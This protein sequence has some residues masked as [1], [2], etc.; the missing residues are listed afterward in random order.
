[1]K[2]EVAFLACSGGKSRIALARVAICGLGALFFLSGV[3]VRVAA[4]EAGAP[5]EESVYA[6]DGVYMGVRGVY[7]I[8]DFDTDFAVDDGWGFG[9]GLRRALWRRSGVLSLPAFR[10]DLRC[11]LQP[12]DGPHRRTRLMV[13]WLR[14]SPVALLGE[15][16]LQ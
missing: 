12:Y 6:R 13:G 8:N 5:A 11:H 3:D 14:R 16:A 15:V 2:A 1:M 10:S 7:G 4:A 9:Y